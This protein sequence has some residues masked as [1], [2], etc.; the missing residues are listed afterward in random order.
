MVLNPRCKYLQRLRH[1]FSCP[2]LHA[3]N[4]L[5]AL[6]AGA[7]L[8]LQIGINGS[9]RTALR[10]ADFGRLCFIFRRHL[11]VGYAVS[12]LL[13]A[14]PVAGLATIPAWMW[15]GG[16]LGAVYVYLSIF[17]TSKLAAAT[18]VG[19]IVAGQ[20]S[21]SMTRRSFRM[22]R[23]SATFDF[24][25]P[26]CRRDFAGRWRLLHSSLLTR[27]NLA[28]QVLAA[29]FYGKQ[30]YLHESR[31]ANSTKAKFSLQIIS[32]D[33]HY[34]EREPCCCFCCWSPASI[35]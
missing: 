7:I 2:K 1:D 9:L 32:G 31:F 17:L 18:L 30:I 20:L 16:A 10:P 8:P 34:L 13:R 25:G 4:I 19:C 26:H 29:R 6:I 33:N 28:L 12:L 23:L 14:A 15:I 3:M 22:A 24:S 21:A 11:R 27:G 35:I 5:L